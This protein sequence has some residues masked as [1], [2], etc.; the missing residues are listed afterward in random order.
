M[1][2]VSTQLKQ[3]SRLKQLEVRRILDTPR[4]EI[5]DRITRLAAKTAVAPISLLTFVD[6]NRQWFKSSFGL[7]EPWNTQRETPLSHSFC[8]YVVA[9]RQPLVVENANQHP[10]VR[11]SKAI[12]DLNVVSYLGVPLIDS[13]GSALGSL[14]VANTQPH[15]WSDSDVQS[16]KDFA[17]VTMIELELRTEVAQRSELEKQLRQSQKL[18]ALGRLASG[19]AHD[20]NNM[21]FVIQGYASFVGERVGSSAEGLGEIHELRSAVERASALTQQLLAFSRKQPLKKQRLLINHVIEG[22]QGMLKQAL[23]GRLELVLELA[24]RL[25]VVEADRTQLEQVMMNL[26]LNARDASPRPGRIIVRTRSVTSGGVPYAELEV[27]DFGKGMDAETVYHIFEPFFTSKEKGVGLGLATV[28][29]IVTQTGGRVVVESVLGHGS[30]FT[31]TLPCVQASEGVAV[32]GGIL[33]PPS[34]K[35]VLPATVLL[36]DDD[37][38]VRSMLAK[39]LRRAGYDLMVAKS[40]LEALRI[41]DKREAQVR[42]ALLDLTMPGMNGGRLGEEL[43]VR[44]PEIA[45]LYMSGY[46]DDDVL[47]QGIT[48]GTVDFVSK[49]IPPDALLATIEEI[50]SRR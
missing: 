45:I 15:A 29:G 32:P 26:V 31:V 34:M 16:L 23:G 18:E 5:F 10:L 33:H 42:L 20:F 1:R 14:A 19:V 17:A 50:L 39:I 6:G 25:G 41:L 46:A 44:V 2:D 22:L 7:P 36:V 48:A 35:A 47:M 11:E 30:T 13:E 38:A 37:A 40:A 24:E 3:A 28:H 4:E 12:P 21:L 27:Q 9:D 8:Q 43:R 49:P